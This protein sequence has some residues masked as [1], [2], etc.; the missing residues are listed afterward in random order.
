[1]WI[2]KLISVSGVNATSFDINIEFSRSDSTGKFQ[3]PFHIAIGAASTIPQIKAL[4]QTQA[5]LLQVQDDLNT[6][7]GPLIGTQ[8]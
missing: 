4:V 1:M 8:L 5:D 6:Q 2:K 7:L 3:M